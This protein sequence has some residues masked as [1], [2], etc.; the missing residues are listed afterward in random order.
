MR[1]AMVGKTVIN[2]DH[3]TAIRVVSPEAAAEMGHPGEDG[4]RV[5]FDGPV[6]CTSGGNA[7]H[8]LYAFGPEADQVREALRRVGL[9]STED[10]P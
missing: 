9:E 10:T 2:L 4:L 3:V 8:A 1:F 6:S 7:S 5:Y